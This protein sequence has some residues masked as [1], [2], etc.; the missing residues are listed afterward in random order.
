MPLMLV[1]L[2][3]VAR[4]DGS[5]KAFCPIPHH[6]CGLQ[7]LVLLRCK[8]GA[9]SI[10]DN[11]HCAQHLDNHCF[12]YNLVDF[13]DHDILILL[14]SLFNC[15]FITGMRLGMTVCASTYAGLYHVSIIIL[16]NLQ[17]RE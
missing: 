13:S 2:L 6:I 7:D 9:A 5:S 8:F 16:V 15:L 10:R 17:I 14:C 4:Q 3:H 1:L 11:D 12:Y